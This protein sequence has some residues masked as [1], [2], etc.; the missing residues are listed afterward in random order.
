MQIPEAVIHLKSSSICIIPHI[1]LNLIQQSLNSP[2]EFLYWTTNY[3][4][5]SYLGT[6]ICVS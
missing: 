1:I 3:I 5:L 4:L 6:V 2:F